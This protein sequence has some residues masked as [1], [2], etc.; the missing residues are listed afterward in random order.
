MAARLYLRSGEVATLFGLDAS[1]SE[2]ALHEK[3]RSGEDTGAGDYG[4]W[5]SRLMQPIM[6]GVCED[7]SLRAEG[8]LKPQDCKCPII[9][10]SRAWNVGPK[11]ETGGRPS[12]LVV[13]QRT[14]ASMREWKEP[15]AMPAKARMRYEAIA[16]AYDVEDVLVGVLVDGYT[17]QVFHVRA[18][19]ERRAEI[20]ARC[21]AFVA[22]V[23]AGNEPDIDFGSDEKAVRKGIAIT[24]VEAAAELVEGLLAERVRLV[25]DRIPA[26]AALKRIEGRLR[27]IDTNIIHLAGAAARLETPAHIIAVERDGKGNPRVVVAEKAPTPLF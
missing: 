19:A 11:M 18:S 1:Q 14:G 23:I 10:P 8:E 22:D 20:K 6:Q 17:S 9:M 16:T 3:L 2:W 12:I 24:R 21:E 26:D 27:E 25:N 15:E 7:H 13:G 5:Q 4:R